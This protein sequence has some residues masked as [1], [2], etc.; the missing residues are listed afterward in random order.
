MS[1]KKLFVII[2][3]KL[4]NLSKNNFVHNNNLYLRSIETPVTK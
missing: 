1:V 4:W 3:T 2:N